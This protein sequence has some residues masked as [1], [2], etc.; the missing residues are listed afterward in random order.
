MDAGPPSDDELPDECPK[1]PEFYQSWPE[2]PDASASQFAVAIEEAYRRHKNDSPSRFF[3][4]EYTAIV[5]DEVSQVDDAHKVP[6]IVKGGI[7]NPA[8]DMIAFEVNSDGSP[9]VGET[10]YL[11]NIELPA[12]PDYIPVE[13]VENQRLRKLLETAAGDDDGV[14]RSNEEPFT[15]SEMNQITKFIA[16]SSSNASRIGDAGGREVAYFD[17]DGTGILLLIRI[18]RRVE[19]LSNTEVWYYITDYVVRRATSSTESRE[20]AELIQCRVPG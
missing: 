5:G 11:D 17:V 19:S 4:A 13:M 7:R 14:A 15:P 9:V 6:L 10:F 20:D 16:T 3:T 12:E 8:M 2:D 18:T 1:I